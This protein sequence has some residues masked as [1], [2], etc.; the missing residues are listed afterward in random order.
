MEKSA[1]FAADV[2]ALDEF[3]Q[4]AGFTIEDVDNL[5]EDERKYIKLEN[6]KLTTIILKQSLVNE[7]KTFS[8]SFKKEELDKGV[9]FREEDYEFSDFYR[10]ISDDGELPF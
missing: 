5:S 2:D 8:K 7:D 3:M 4:I 1:F 9:V 6:E 10:K